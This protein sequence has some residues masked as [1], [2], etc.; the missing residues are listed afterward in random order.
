M[1][2]T[3]IG[4]IWD[5]LSSIVVAQGY[6]RSRNPFDFDQQPDSRL[7]LVF[8]M[9]SSRSGTEGYLG[10]YQGELHRVDIFLARRAKSDP[11]G[12]ARQLKVDMDLVE[13]TVLADSPTEDYIL[14]DESVESEIRDP[15]P[16]DDYVVGRLSFTVDFDAFVDVSPAPSPPSE[17][18]LI[19]STGSLFDVTD[20]G[21]TRTGAVDSVL[22]IE[23]A[24]AAAMSWVAQTSY[25]RA[26]IYFPSGD[27]KISRQIDALGSDRISWLGESRETSRLIWDDTADR[28]LVIDTISA[29]PTTSLLTADTIIGTRS[30]TVA[31]S[32]GL[33]VG[34]W[35]YLE[36]SADYEGSLLT[37]IKAISGT[38]IT[39][40]D[41]IPC[42]LTVAQGA[43]FYSYVTYPLL[44]GISIE[45]LTFQC[46]T[47]A[48]VSK[49]T[50][51]LLSRLSGFRVH[52][53]RFS[54]STGPLVTT[55]T[56]YRSRV[57]NSILE[58]AVTAAGS[59]VEAQTSTGLQLVDNDVSMC[60][61]GLVTTRSPYTRIRG[62]RVHGR[63]TS[64][65]LGR[66]IKLDG[67]S[68]YSTVEGNVVSDPN[69]F[70][71]F[72]EDSSYCS[73][74][75]NTVTGCG[76]PDTT[77]QHGIELGG[78]EDLCL[79]N[80]ITGNIISH[81]SGAGIAINPTTGAAAV[82]MH[83]TISGNTITDC[84]QG[85][86]VVAKSSF[87]TIGSNTCRSDG[88]T[89][90][91]GVI[92][93]VSL[94]TR[95]TVTGNTLSNSSGTS[96]PGIHTSS[97][98]GSNTVQGNTL[99]PNLT[100]SLH[101]TDSPTG[102][103]PNVFNYVA[104]ATP[105]SLVETDAWTITI[106]G[107]TLSNSSQGFRLR[108]VFA[109]ADTNNVKMLRVYFGSGTFSGTVAYQG[110]AHSVSLDFEVLFNTASSAFCWTV[111][112]SN[113]IA[114]GLM[115]GI[116]YLHQALDWTIDQTIRITMQNS[117]A[118]AADI[119]FEGGKL[120][121]EGL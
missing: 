57:S 113:R 66:G 98:D 75:A 68:N 22:N 15:G 111:Y 53:C 39:L 56:C 19:A 61:F 16:D 30:V 3:T 34:G 102:S 97:S 67:G 107:G 45:H 109:I 43:T 40:E 37:K 72:L 64:V 110:A 36:S 7:N 84:V 35:A 21:A 58:H 9:A 89:I 69:L 10:G 95:C 76:L 33:S 81:S 32:A 104:V 105:A 13:A 44:T 96:A 90:V 119:T 48:P 14:Q 82:P 86:I 80:S 12:A 11:W 116:Q 88:S 103:R 2:L 92:R 94:S 17:P 78:E 99:G 70:G 77:Q 25:N 60:Q 59:G 47:S 85:A 79:Y 117:A 114:T 27:Y 4:A 120:T 65:A 55:R 8:H 49:Q 115:P 91:G 63:Q 24:L 73:I 83:A 20:Y 51:L 26:L 52:D 50:L 118:N 23:A 62:N 6:T 101:A 1:A 29:S 38:T 106:P 28:G 87:V 42:A 100:Y 46:S 71:I 41:T 121:W 18:Y 74:A 31:S 108:A 5:R 54:G 93:L 112:I